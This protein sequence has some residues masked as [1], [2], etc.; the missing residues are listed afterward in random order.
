MAAGD[1]RPFFGSISH[2]PPHFPNNMPE[3]YRT[4]YRPEEIPLPP[5]VPDPELQTVVQRRRNDG[6]EPA[7]G[8]MSA[9][10]IDG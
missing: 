6:S 2:G 3:H 4:L 1:G 8:S 5:G 7:N 9:T 10:R